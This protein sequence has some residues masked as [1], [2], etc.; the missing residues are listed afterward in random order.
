MPVNYIALAVSFGVPLALTLLVTVIVVAV[1]RKRRRFLSLLK[2]KLLSIQLP[3]KPA[4][5]AKKPLEE[6][7]LSAQLLS[8]LSSL[9]MP[10]SLETA[11]HNVGEDIHFYM[12]VPEEAMDFA[13]R[14]VQG[15]WPE[16]QVKPAEDY[17]IFN[18][19]GATRVAFVKQKNHYAL[20][21]RTYAEAGV[22]TFLT[23]LNNFSKVEQTGEGLALQIIAKPASASAAKNISRMIYNLKKGAKLQDTLDGKSYS[24]KKAKPGEAPEP[25]IID[26]EA[27][28]L[29]NQKA[30]K[31]MLEVNA[32]LV[33]SAMSPYRAEELLYNM[34]GSLS[35]FTAPGHN[36]FKIVEP[37]NPQKPVF[38]YIFREFDPA[39]SM[40]LGTDE[41]ASIWHLPA[42][43]TEV[44][45][46]KWL[47]AREAAPPTVLPTSGTL[48]GESAFRGESKPIFITDDDRRRHVYTVG[49]TGTGKSTLL[50]NMVISDIKNG[51]GVAV[52]DPHG[53]L[54]DEILGNIPEARFK[55]VVV[56]EPGDLEKP[57][58]LN[59][60]E[61]DPSRPE[62]KTFIVNE[63]QSIFN[64]LFTAET[65]GP[66]FEQYMRNALLLLMDDPN[67]KATLMEVPRVFTD[68]EYRKRLLA[69]ATNPTVVD[70]WSKEAAK[71][72]GDASLANMTP[73][74]TSKFNNFIANDYMRPIIGQP[75]SSLNFRKS[76]DEGQILLVNLSKG[77]IGD[78]NAGL[79]GMVVV[80]KILLA[81]LSRTDVPEA[82]RKDF[83]L[84][85]DEFQNF[86]TD[87]IATILSEARKYRLNLVVAHQFV[88][89]LTEKIRDA[90]FGNVGSQVVFRVGAEDA[91]F[92]LK[93]FEPVFSESD[94]VNVD[95]LN[96]LAKLLI[97]G[98]TSR[99]FTM[100]LLLRSPRFV[101]GL[102][103]KLKEQSRQQYGRNRQEVEDDILKRLRN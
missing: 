27:L 50:S 89:Q 57:L 7:N 56:F 93:Q 19:Q 58:G 39:Q 42:T 54:V 55:D 52:V 12:A 34:T 1:K 40:I 87:S 15:L 9:K 45:K 77:K 61:Y 84:Y 75:S 74:I 95:N 78:I 97:N 33:S 76:M 49:Q 102:A 6:I 69:K 23:L 82:Q 63:M 16:A 46:L 13:A 92:L 24:H 3:Q 21:I 11:V 14:Q 29:L 20:P 47:K 86:T 43:G 10:F 83:N 96:A 66:M 70:F 65:M 35:Q 103:A 64:R 100:K 28:K 4:D 59:M 44:P 25:V 88:A 79:L 51:K 38:Q 72:G 31:P 90:V 94:L 91:K 30:S 18:S 37:K 85:I 41:I 67:E 53:E 22:D 26:E 36:E 62:Q 71:A 99:P 80:G 81:A 101:E 8:L 32:R 2:L 68:I 5:A 73:Y 60:L 17:T 48:I 98:Q